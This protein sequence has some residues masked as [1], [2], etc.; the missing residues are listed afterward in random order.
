MRKMYARLKVQAMAEEEKLLASATCDESGGPLKR[1][2]KESALSSS[3]DSMEEAEEGSDNHTHHSNLSSTG[4]DASST[5]TPLGRSVHVSGDMFGKCLDLFAFMVAYCKPLSL[6]QIPSVDVLESALSNLSP[7]SKHVKHLANRAR[8]TLG[9]STMLSSHTEALT[10]DES[11]SLLNSIGVALCKPLLV[12]YNRVMAIDNVAPHLGDCAIVVNELTWKEIPRVVLTSALCRHVGM[13]EVDVLTALLGR[14]YTSHADSADR[15]ALRLIRRRLWHRYSAHVWRVTSAYCPLPTFNCGS[16]SGK[17]KHPPPDFLLRKQSVHL[18]RETTAGLVVRVNVPSTY[19]RGAYRTITSTYSQIALL[20]CEIYVFLF[21]LRLTNTT[22]TSGTGVCLL[23]TPDLAS[24]TTTTDKSSPIAYH[25]IAAA[26]MVIGLLQVYI[27]DAGKH[28]EVQ[29]NALVVLYRAL[30]VNCTTATTTALHTA[31]SSYAE[32]LRVVV[33]MT[34]YRLIWTYQSPDRVT[35]R[36]CKEVIRIHHKHFTTAAAS[37][38]S[39]STTPGAVAVSGAGVNISET[40]AGGVLHRDSHIS[41]WVG[42]H[43]AWKASPP[44][45]RAITS[46]WANHTGPSATVAYDPIAHLAQLKAASSDVIDGADEK[47]SVW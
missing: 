22:A 44:L 7:E 46:Y 14:G 33:M 5:P 38:A 23:D 19:S 24:N 21:H 26:K 12:E 9:C 8:K 18:G 36:C 41:Q 35:A 32:Q 2:G 20:W 34:L 29:S 47:V 27:A 25:V 40:F 45:L 11:T 6:A 4:L 42:I 39:T 1:N 31:S 15:K 28:V 13:S 17:E 3:N 43:A 37:S 30:G 16:G 10:M